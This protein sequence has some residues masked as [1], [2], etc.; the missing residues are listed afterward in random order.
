MG[1]M[2]S[3]SQ[4]RAEPSSE[5]PPR[6]R[7]GM[8]SSG[9]SIRAQPLEGNAYGICTTGENSCTQ[10]K[11]LICQLLS[12]NCNLCCVHACTRFIAFGT[13]YCSRFAST[14]DSVGRTCLTGVICSCHSKWLQRNIITFYVICI[15]FTNPSKRDRHP[16]YTPWHHA[17]A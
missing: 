14:R 4:R 9:Q 13:G 16:K 1:T 6:A 10:D 7:Q 11:P 5:F 2:M 17:M 15:S 8:L 12:C 3:C